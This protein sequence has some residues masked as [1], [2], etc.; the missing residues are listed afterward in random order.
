MEWNLLLG[1]RYSDRVGYT[2]IEFGRRDEAGFEQ[3]LT[4]GC[5]LKAVAGRGMVD[6]WFFVTSARLG[7]DFTLI[8]PGGVASSRERLAETLEDV[9]HVYRRAEDYRRAID[10]RLFGLGGERY[11]SLVKLLIQL[12]QPQLTRRPDEE[13]LSRALAAAL[14]PVDQAILSV[15]AEAFHDL[16]QQRT[17][18]GAL[19]DT[20]ATVDRFMHSYR[21]YAATAARRLAADVRTSHS[22][23]QSSQREMA[24]ARQ[25]LERAQA[26][27]R[28]AEQQ[29]QHVGTELAVARGQAPS[30]GIAPRCVSSM[31][32]SAWRTWP[33][34]A[35]RRR[36]LGERRPRRITNGNT[37]SWTSYSS[38]RAATSDT[39]RSRP[40]SSITSLDSRGCHPSRRSC[41]P[42][43]SRR[44]NTW[45]WP[46]TGTLPRPRPPPPVRSVNAPKPRIT[47]CG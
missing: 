28:A 9:G 27:D 44:P 41:W 34:S 37:P 43:S 29:R 35:T 23:F 15:V 11:E 3:F 42:H 40:R 2:W 12:R 24:E 14:R 18:L 20:H 26:E 33:I 47:C 1:D 10:E 19:K 38:W 30:C 45:L 31:A 5:G 39:C 4:L 46:P 16:E 25:A 13:R 17:D 21:R 22:A 36:R 7:T 32:P 6:H 8:G